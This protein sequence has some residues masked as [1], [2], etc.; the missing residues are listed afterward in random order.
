VGNV[1]RIHTLIKLSIDI[2]I[3]LG[4]TSDRILEFGLCNEVYRLIPHILGN[5]QIEMEPSVRILSV[6]EGFSDGKGSEILKRRGRVPHLVITGAERYVF[7][8]PFVAVNGLFEDVQIFLNLSELR[9][10]H[11]FL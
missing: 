4:C 8:I 1:L 9:F 3:E 6:A 10:H 5:F 2:E 7:Q 11:V